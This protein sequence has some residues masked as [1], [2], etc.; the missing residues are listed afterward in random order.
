MYFGEVI[1]ARVFYCRLADALDAD[2]VITARS[3]TG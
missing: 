2:L 3:P 1:V